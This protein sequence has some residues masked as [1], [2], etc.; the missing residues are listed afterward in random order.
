[1]EDTT[2]G[3]QSELVSAKL[4]CSSYNDGSN[5]DELETQH[6]RLSSQE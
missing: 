1:M 5:Q 3:F 4:S 2:L 6:Y